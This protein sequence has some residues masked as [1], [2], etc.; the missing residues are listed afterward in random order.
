VLLNKPYGVLCQFSGDGSRPTLKDHVDVPGVYPAG[1]LDLDSEGLVLFT[2]DG[3]LA[4]RLMHPR[5]EM[6]RVYEA[7]VQGRLSPEVLEKLRRGVHLEDGPAAFTSLTPLD[8]QPTG[9]NRRYRVALREGR[10]REVRR[11]F[12]AVG[13]R[14]NRLTRVRYGRVEL[15]RDLKPGEWRELAS[16]RVKELFAK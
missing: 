1:R 16:A 5:Y 6:E 2:D 13:A 4:N 10:N 9:T 3:D 11:L 8:D 7:R 12:E 15:P 14:V